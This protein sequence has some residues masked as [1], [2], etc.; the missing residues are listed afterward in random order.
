MII[1]G[2]FAI[3]EAEHF[4]GGLAVTKVDRIISQ[5][6]VPHDKKPK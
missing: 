3:L 2:T 1:F 4:V 5:E 6:Y